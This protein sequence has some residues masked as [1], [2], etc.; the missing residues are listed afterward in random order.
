MVFGCRKGTRSLRGRRKLKAI[1]FNKA[2]AAKDVLEMVDIDPIEPEPNEVRVKVAYSAVN[3]TD[4]KRRE[5]GRELPN[6]SPIVSCNDGAGVIE[7]VGS[8]VDPSQIGKNVWIF[9]A[10]AYRPMGTMAEFCTLPAWMAPE[11]PDEASLEDGACLGV[12][13]VTAYHSIFSDGSVE[14]KTVLVSGGGGRVGSYAVQMAKLDG[15]TV[16]AMVGQPDN[17]KYVKELGAD[18]VV[19]Y[20]NDDVAKKVLELTD[21]RGVDRISE[22]AFGAN[23]DLFDK[24]VVPN[25]VVTAYSSDAVETPLLPFLNLMFKNITLRPFT[26]YQLPEATKREYFASINGMLKKRQLKHRVAAH[27]PFT[28]EGAVAA[29]EQI[30]ADASAGVCMVDVG[31]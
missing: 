19:N 8:N 23:V 14:G 3:P 9:G 10:Q 6:F 11:L 25:G 20:K 15:A 28:L 7:A 27:H 1:Q 12:P 13:A 29:H 21:G 31:G 17:E 2:G 4:V 16:I 30:E 24:V 22:V 5:S 18:H 26:I